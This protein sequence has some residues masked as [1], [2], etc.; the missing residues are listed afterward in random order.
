M[1]FYHTSQTKKNQYLFIMSLKTQKI[2]LKTKLGLKYL[3]SRIKE[4]KVDGN[5]K[6]NGG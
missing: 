6:G 1:G 5:N 4:V 2:N 3:L